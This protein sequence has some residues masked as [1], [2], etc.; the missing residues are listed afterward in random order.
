MQRRDDSK[1]WKK[2]VQQGFLL[3]QMQGVNR[4]MKIGVGYCYYNDIESIK[5]GITTFVNN[6]DYVFAI[7]GRFSLR[8]GDDF[9]TDG[10]TEFLEKY[11]NVIIEKFVGME[12]DKRQRYIELCKK[13]DIDVL[14]IIDTDEF[15]LEA[16][17]LTFKQNLIENLESPENIHGVKF[18]YNEKDW[19]PY[20]RIWI[21]PNEISYY[22]THNIFRVQGNLIRSP[23]VKPIFGISMGMNDNLRSEEYLKKT[24]EYQKKMLDYEI[25]IRQD[26]RNG[27]LR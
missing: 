14:L 1:G 20:P 5:R 25:P 22:K 13:Y 9:S 6:V 24:S 27:K 23:V 12:H 16:D 26:Y 7:D 10:S 2:L 3:L 21:R 8:D 4:G 11:K 17:W 19:T 18:Y 15:V